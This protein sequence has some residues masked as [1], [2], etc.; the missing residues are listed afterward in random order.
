MNKAIS[1]VFDAPISYQLA[2]DGR[3]EAVQ[4]KYAIY[5]DGTIGFELGAYDTSRELVIDPILDYGTYLGGTGSDTGYGIAVDASGNIYVAGYT[6]S[7]DFPTQSGYAAAPTSTGDAFISK[8][9]ATG[10]TL[11]Y[12]TYFGG[13][14][15]EW[16]TDIAVDASGKAYVTGYTTSTDLPTLNAYD[17]SLSGSQNA[18]IALFDTNLSGASS[19]LYSSYFGGSTA[20]YATSIA[21]DASNNAYITGWTQSSN[22]PTKNA[23][24]SSYGG[25]QD[26]FV[27]KF[28]L[29]QS[30]ASSLV[31][32]TYIG[33][34]ETDYGFGIAVDT[35]G[36]AAFTGYTRSSNFPVTAN[37]YD[38]SYNGADDVFVAKLNSTGDTMVYA[39]F[40]GSTIST[41]SEQAQNIALDSSGN[42][43]ITGFASHSTFPTTAGA[44]DTTFNGGTYDAFVAKFDPSLSGASS[45]VYSTFF[46]GDG[47]S[48]TGLAIAVDSSGKAYVTGRTSSTNLPTTGDA[49]DSSLGGSM[50]GF[51][52]TLSSDGADLDYL[53][54]LGGDASDV[55]NDIALGSNE[56]IYLTGYSSSSDFPTTAG[57]YDEVNNGQDAFVVKFASG[58]VLDLDANDSS[59]AAG[60]NF[61]TRFTGTG[62]VAVADNDATIADPLSTNLVSLTVTLTNH[63]DGANEVLTANTAGTSITAIYNSGTGVLSLTGTDTLAHYQQV[64]RTVTYNNT[65]GSPNT[66]DRIITFVA[67]DGTQTSGTATTT[68]KLANL[69]PVN[70]VPG[71]QTATAVGTVVFSVANGNAISVSDPD[72]GSNPVQ[73]TLTATQGTLTLAGITGLTFTTGD[74]TADATMTFTGTIANINTALNGMAFNGDPFRTSGT[75]SVQIVSDDLGNTGLGG[76]QSD[77]DTVTV[78]MVPLGTPYMITGT[79]TGNGGTL[80]ITGLGFQPDVVIIKETSNNKV[81]VIK[82]STM[83]GAD[84]KVMTGATATATNNITSLDADGFTVS[85]GGNIANINSQTYTFIAFKSSPGVTTVG[86]YSGTGVDGNAVTGLGFSP[87]LVFVFDGSNQAGVFRN[88][89]DANSYDFTKNAYTT[90]I[91]SLDA[92][93][94]TLGADQ[95]ANK[96]GDTYYYIAWNQIPGL[97]KVGSYTG[98]AVDDTNITG[99]GFAPEWLMVQ[100]SSGSDPAVNHTEA[101]GASTDISNYF[102]GTTSTTNLIQQLQADGFQVGNNADVNANGTYYSYMAWSQETGPTISA[103]ANQSTPEDT[104][105]GPIAFTVG[106]A[107]T[108][109]GSLS[110]KAVSSNQAV[111]TDANIVFGG[112]GSSRTLIAD[113]SGQCPTA[114]ATSRSMSPTARRSRARSSL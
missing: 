60:N 42:I 46:G 94:F 67:D 17:T 10:N 71:E 49:H 53:T 4:S 96:N 47:N 112:S 11:L 85:N 97:M 73:V 57:A 33:G 101:Q 74:G 76:A 66:S 27:A 51:L 89:A 20:E 37:A 87:E 52:A 6:G 35:A 59:G 91:T 54:Y 111:L 34:S 3:R 44:Y 72:A 68:V 26:A 39:T 48:D 62:A 69:P 79:Y 32:S 1:S 45:L 81:A 16:F 50:D 70:T 92:S 95:R 30:G 31:Y 5:E 36:N 75:G 23:Y 80:N 82:T 21:L 98:N 24:Q 15:S 114:R 40:M 28:D 58:P 113:A 109:A 25:T 14:N 19:L 13:N 22:M 106:D 99:V 102:T 104:S 18:I 105:L 108:A 38:N 93:G 107:E 65:T 64:L 83:S 63:P 43:Y 103:I 55:A 88:S 86:S 41:V 8:F 12:S 78:N 100:S 77:T 61:T 84:S 2:N 9:D 90:A 7:T 56:D 29:T 110:V